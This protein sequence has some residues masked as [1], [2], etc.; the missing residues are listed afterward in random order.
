[1]INNNILS[2]L[3]LFKSRVYC[4]LRLVVCEATNKLCFGPVWKYRIDK[5]GTLVFNELELRECFEFEVFEIIFPR[6]LE[7]VT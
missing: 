7:F 1:M 2:F 4:A 5:Q 6:A 3:F